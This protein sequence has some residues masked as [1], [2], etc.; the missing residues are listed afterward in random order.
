[1]TKILFRGCFWGHLTLPL[2]LKGFSENY[3]VYWKIFVNILVHRT[4]FSNFKLKLR[5]KQI[6]SKIRVSNNSH[7]ASKN[8][9]DLR[10]YLLQY[11]L[12]PILQGTWRVK[13]WRYCLSVGLPCSQ[14]CV[15]AHTKRKDQRTSY[16]ICCLCQYQYRLTGYFFLK[17]NNYSLPLFRTIYRNKNCHLYL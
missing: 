7:N 2:A 11:L 8:Q 17:Q 4:S 9:S 15:V 10:F 1:M 13:M 6:Q 3:F 16:S 14:T 5:T 12:L